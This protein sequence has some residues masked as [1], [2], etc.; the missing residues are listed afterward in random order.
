MAV[1]LTAR[2]QT[3]KFG[4]VFEAHVLQA[5]EFVHPAETDVMPGGFCFTPGVARAGNQTYGSHGIRMKKPAMPEPAMA[6]FIRIY[7]FTS[8]FP[9]QPVQ[10]LLAQRLRLRQML[11]LRLPHRLPLPPHRRGP[12]REVPPP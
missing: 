1:Q 7:P 3:M 12:A 8:W 6:G 5:C 10:R 11:R 4:L 2:G 9:W